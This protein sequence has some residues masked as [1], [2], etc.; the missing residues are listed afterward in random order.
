MD[1]EAEKKGYWA[2]C[3]DEPRISPY[4]T[5]QETKEWLKGYDDACEHFGITQPKCR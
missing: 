3:D 1:V 5:E 4:K 2:A